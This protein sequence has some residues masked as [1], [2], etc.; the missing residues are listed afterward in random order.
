LALQRCLR[1]SHGDLAR[2]YF[3]AT[4]KIVGDAWQLATGGDLS[5]PE[6]DG[7]RPIPVRI[8]NKYVQQ[9]QATAE[10]D[11]VVAERLSNVTGLIDPPQRLLRPAVI[12]RVAKAALDRRRRA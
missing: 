4:S 6:V 9:V 5:L 8:I 2:R 12:A 11:I 7:P 1:Q 3:H 10:H